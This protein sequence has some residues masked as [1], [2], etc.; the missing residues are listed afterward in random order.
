MT[1]SCDVAIC[2]CIMCPPLP[3]LFVANVYETPLIC[4]IEGSGKLRSTT[5]P[6]TEANSSFVSRDSDTEVGSPFWRMGRAVMLEKTDESIRAAGSASI[7]ISSFVRKE[8]KDS[9]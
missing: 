6:R 2:T 8:S 9:L 3:L 1:L 5:G 4:I 7:V